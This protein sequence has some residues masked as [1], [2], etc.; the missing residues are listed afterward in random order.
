MPSRVGRDGHATAAA[1]EQFLEAYFQKYFSKVEDK[2]ILSYDFAFIEAFKI[3]IRCYLGKL[4][5][6]KVYNSNETLL[7]ENWPDTSLYLFKNQRPKYLDKMPPIAKDYQ[8]I[9]CTLDLNEFSKT[10]NAKDD[11]VRIEIL[12]LQA[13]L[14]SN[15]L[16]VECLREIEQFLDR[17]DVDGSLAFRTLCNR[18]TIAV[19]T[20]LIEKC[21]QAVLQYAKVTTF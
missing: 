8:K 19:T 18:D 11:T 3:L 17:E 9:I 5:Q 15:S 16:P 21:P 6:S 2:S 13:I 12:K 1:L 7:S 4:L 14:A 20:L 10:N